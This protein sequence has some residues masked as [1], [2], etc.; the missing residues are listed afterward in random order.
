MQIDTEKENPLKAA[1][2]FSTAGTLKK[3]LRHA[4]MNHMTLH[5]KRIYSGT[6]VWNF[7]TKYCCYEMRLGN[8][9]GEKK[10]RDFFFITVTLLHWHHQVRKIN[11]QSHHLLL[12]IVVLEPKI[13]PAT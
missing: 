7:N 2:S 12:N 3:S 13:T 6:N 1:S 4:F 9:S 11:R 5:N 8:D 10:P